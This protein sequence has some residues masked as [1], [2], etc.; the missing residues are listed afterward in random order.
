VALLVGGGVDVDLDE[1]DARVA[2]VLL[3]P[4]GVDERARV[5]VI[6]VTHR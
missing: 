2:E 4:I 6:V 3:G 1:A 5:R